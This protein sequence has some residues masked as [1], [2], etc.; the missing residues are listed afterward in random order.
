MKCH[1]E[2]GL[3][4]V[5]I[6]IHLEPIKAAMPLPRGLQTRIDKDTL[7]AG[8]YRT[9]STHPPCRRSLPIQLLF[10]IGLFPVVL[11]PAY[12]MC[13]RGVHHKGASRDTWNST[14]SWSWST[15][16]AQPSSHAFPGLP[17][18]EQLGQ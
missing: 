16:A 12:C 5:S 15:T 6:Y 17:C 18:S 13:Y 10:C 9:E 7:G 2:N 3:S 1:T 4:T 14:A 8:S 11:T